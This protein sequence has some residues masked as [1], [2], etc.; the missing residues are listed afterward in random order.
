RSS[1]LKYGG[2]A[3]QAAGLRLGHL[4]LAA[5]PVEALSYW[6]TALEKVQTPADLRNPYVEL[7]QVRAWF[8]QALRQ[9]HDTQDAERTQAV[10]E[11]Y[12]KIA[13]GGEADRRFAQA[14]EG[15]AQQLADALK[16]TPDAV[17]S[18]DVQ[19]QYRR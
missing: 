8:E 4:A 16:L 12:R 3:G 11:L 17:Q 7:E 9:L 18:K 14:A 10:A 5:S 1:D 19:A 2:P 15:R 6:Q 13:P